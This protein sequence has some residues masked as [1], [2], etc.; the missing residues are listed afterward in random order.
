MSNFSSEV[1]PLKEKKQEQADELKERDTGRA[2]EVT[3]KEKSPF[4]VIP[5]GKLEKEASHSKDI[6]KGMGAE[7]AEGT[8]EKKGLRERLRGGV[9]TV[10]EKFGI[11]GV[12]KD[13]TAKVDAAA[14][15][16]GGVVGGAM[17]ALVGAYYATINSLPLEASVI[18]G[19]I[20][21]AV[22]GFFAVQTGGS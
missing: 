6:E 9:T 19:A 8:S 11:L 15:L 12:F 3:K 5:L 2:A 16:F 17:G 21:G 13:K 7:A 18:A 1:M 20:I 4:K 10:A 14:V 22:L